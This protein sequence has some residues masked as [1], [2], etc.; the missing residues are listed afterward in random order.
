MVQNLLGFVWLLI[1][2]F[3]QIQKYSYLHM[4]FLN[5]KLRKNSFTQIA[6]QFEWSTSINCHLLSTSTQHSTGVVSFHG[7][8]FL[9]TIKSTAG[10]FKNTCSISHYITKIMS[11]EV[12]VDIHRNDF[13]E[14]TIL[15]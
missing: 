8:P 13:Q 11:V 12:R 10:F 1:S 5:P 9:R 15:H 3:I 2:V 6:S 4:N 14:T 7:L